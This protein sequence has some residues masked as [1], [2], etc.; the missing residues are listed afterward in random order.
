M[1]DKARARET[2]K[3]GRRADPPRQRRAVRTIEEALDVARDD[4]LPG[5][6]QGLG[7]RRRTRHAHLLGR[8]DDLRAQYDTARNEAER[9]FGDGRRLSREVPR[10]SAPHRDP[11]LRRHARPRR[12]T[13]A[14][15]MLDP[16][17]PPEADRGV[18]VAGARRRSC[19]SGWARRPSGSARPSNYVERRHDRVPLTRT[20]SSTSWR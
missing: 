11:G 20:A 6:P 8:D 7:R 18:A 5:D 15:A 2:A 3:N 14:S 13:S 1:G 4:R 10:A 12:R 9:A 16:A 17:P 19:A